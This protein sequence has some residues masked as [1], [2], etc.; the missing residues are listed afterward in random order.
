MNT[1]QEADGNRLHDH[2]ETAPARR[3]SGALRCELSARNLA[4]AHAFTHEATW[5]STPSVVYAEDEAGLHGNFFPAS[6]RRILRHPAWRE[7]LQKSYTAS[8]RIAH[9][10]SRQR[11]ELDCAASS[12]A[13]L[14][15]IFCHPT[16]LRSAPLRALLG[17][18]ED[19]MPRF[20]VRARVALCDGHDDRTEIDMVLSE[21]LDTTNQLFVEAKL[22]EADFQSARPALLARYET[23]EE[24]FETARLPRSRGQFRSYQ[25]LRNVMA[26][27]HYEARFA[28]ML[29][30]RRSDLLED[31]YMVYR[32]VRDATLRSRLHV[33]TW[34]EIALC[35]GR[36]M[37]RFLAE[38]YGIAPG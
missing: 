38:K 16:V 15:S 14:M 11:R 26:A 20:G 2:E 18:G 7:R 8:H 21:E 30:G 25:L 31:I 22:S 17:V 4:R 24:C 13:L 5:G 28:V 27:H 37:Q 36:P 12:D 1:P 6:Y 3:R 32:A 10:E 34:Q 23:F 19:A 9:A 35:V 29:D 33:V